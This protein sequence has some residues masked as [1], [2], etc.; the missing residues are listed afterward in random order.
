[1]RRPVFERLGQ[2]GVEMA[3][4]GSPLHAPEDKGKDELCV[5]ID[6]IFVCHDCAMEYYLDFDEAV[7]EWRW[8]HA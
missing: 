2:F 5:R 3:R 8:L 1:M 7:E 6:R 4:C